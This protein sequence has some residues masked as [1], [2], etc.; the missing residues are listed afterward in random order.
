MLNPTVRIA[1]KTVIVNRTSFFIYRRA[2]RTDIT[3][4]VTR[5]SPNNLQN[6]FSTL[7]TAYAS[8]YL[9]FKEEGAI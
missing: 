5:N 3:Y 7:E 8:E 9:D 6:I 2:P 1:A 4:V